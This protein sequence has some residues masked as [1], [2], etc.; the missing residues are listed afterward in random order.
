MTLITRRIEKLEA[1]ILPPR[2]SVYVWA[3]EDGIDAARAKRFPEG[4]PDDTD[5]IFVTWRT[6]GA[7]EDDCAQH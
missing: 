7:R 4:V 1:E 5:I 3:M 2:R 6:P